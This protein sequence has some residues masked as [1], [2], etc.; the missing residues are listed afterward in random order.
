MITYPRLLRC[1]LVLL[2]CVAGGGAVAEPV[3]VEMDSVLRAEPRPDA[4][5]V[6]QLARGTAGD[7]TV[8]QGAWVQMATGGQ[9]GWIYTFN[10]RFTGA[11]GS[12]GSGAGSLLG[13]VFAPR[14]QVNVTSTIGIRG[15]D[16]EDL[17]QARLDAAQLQ[18]LDS[19][20]ANRDQAAAH[21]QAA[22]LAAERVEYLT[23]GAP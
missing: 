20:A 23:G 16:E 17:R 3:T 13:R 4:A 22:G 6:A 18:Q 19:Y 9:T 7:A 10:V 1:C 12:G 15:L 21:A 5:V 14:Q 11:G 8:R 2:L